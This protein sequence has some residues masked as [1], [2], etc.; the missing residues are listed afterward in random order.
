MWVPGSGAGAGDKEKIIPKGGL[1]EHGRI[2]EWR[3]K[4]EVMN[5]IVWTSEAPLALLYFVHF[6]IKLFISI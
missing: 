3:G 1:K 6:V 2:S 5:E 4:E